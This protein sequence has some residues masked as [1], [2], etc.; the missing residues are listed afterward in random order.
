MKSTNYFRNLSS[1]THT[2]GVRRNFQARQPSMWP[3]VI[4]RA[5]AEGDKYFILFVPITLLPVA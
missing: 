4:A 2:R 1:D 5:A 3:C